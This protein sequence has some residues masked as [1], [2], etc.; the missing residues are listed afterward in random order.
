M[1]G[2]KNWINVH[3]IAAAQWAGTWRTLFLSEERT[4]F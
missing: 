4:H 3:V 2:K 1:D